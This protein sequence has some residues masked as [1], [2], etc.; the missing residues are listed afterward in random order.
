MN[1]MDEQICLSI[2]SVKLNDHAKSAFW[3]KCILPLKLFEIVFTLY[4]TW[5]NI[6]L[7]RKFYF[8]N[9]FQ[10]KNISRI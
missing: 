7:K 9:Y 6:S 2:C 4:Y 10:L 5:Y 3:Q 1:I 8:K